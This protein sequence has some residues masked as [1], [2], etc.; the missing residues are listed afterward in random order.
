MPRSPIYEVA[1]ALPFAIDDF[2][3]VAT[4]TLQAKIWA[5]RA[6]SAIGT[7][8]AERVFRPEYGTTI[9]SKLW[10]SVTTMEEAIEEQIES[11]FERDLQN[12][13]LDDVVVTYDEKTETV[14]AEVSY[15]LPNNEQ[16]S[17][18]IGVATIS[19]TDPIVE[20]L[21]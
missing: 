10:D 2:G 4:T 13:T 7:T 11:V 5:D 19:S 6:R 21:L 16:T 18:T 1:I 20:E 3:S 12:L 14:F 15:F 9:P 8:L 17:V